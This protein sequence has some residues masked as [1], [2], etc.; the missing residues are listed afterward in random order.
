MAYNA[1]TNRLMTLKLN[2]STFTFENFQK[3]FLLWRFSLDINLEDT[4]KII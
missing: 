2:S 1:K 3:L 4:T